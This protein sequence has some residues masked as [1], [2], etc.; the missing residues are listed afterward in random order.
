MHADD[1]TP[2]AESP[3][4]WDSVDNAFWNTVR[5]NLLHLPSLI[6]LAW[7]CNAG[8]PRDGMFKLYPGPTLT[9]LA[10]KH[11][12]FCVEEPVMKTIQ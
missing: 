7:I 2:L 12:W 1:A 10:T 5:V 9:A 3:L 11:Y 8:A 4:E 6:L